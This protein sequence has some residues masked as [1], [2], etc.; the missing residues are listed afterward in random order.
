[1][2]Q[3]SKGSRPGRDG[4]QIDVF[5]CDTRDVERARDLAGQPFAMRA[6]L[7]AGQQCQH[8]I[9]VEH[10]HAAGARRRVEGQSDQGAKG[11]S[12]A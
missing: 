9:V 7:I 8:A 12:G 6:R 10:S 11:A 4:E 5:L 3:S 2:P 1:L